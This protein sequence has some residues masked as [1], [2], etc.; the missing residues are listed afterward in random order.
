MLILAIIAFGM[1]VGW[2]AQLVA[3]TRLRELVRWGE[4]QTRVEGRVEHEG[5]QHRLAVEVREGERN[6]LRE[7]KAVKASDYFGALAVVLFT[8]D[9]VGLVRGSPDGRRRLL[10]RAVFTARPAHLAVVVEYRRA[11]EARNRLLRDGAE[12]AL[13]EVYEATLA[14]R[15]A[16]LMAARK[17]FVDRLAPRFAEVFGTIAGEGLA[18]ELRYRPSLDAG[19]EDGAA[20]L[21]AAWATDRERDRRLRSPRPVAVS[22]A[23]DA[24]QQNDPR[25]QR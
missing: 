11:L 16:R 10:D 18:G 8:P 9:D 6:A 14:D 23:E 5:L 13:V 3:A 20:G 4:K 25:E 22:P 15:G 2:L 1:L 7:G 19:L 12:D 21:Q 17:S 24:G